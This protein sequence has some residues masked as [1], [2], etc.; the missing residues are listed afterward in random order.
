MVG[1]STV[2]VALVM[3]AVMCMM[4][5]CTLMVGGVGEAAVMDKKARAIDGG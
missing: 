5:A 3:E 2:P 4:Q 1:I